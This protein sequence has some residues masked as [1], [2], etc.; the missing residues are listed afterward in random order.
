MSKQ[1][2]SITTIIL[3]AVYIGL[4]IVLLPHTAWAFRKWEPIES[5]ELFWGISSADIIS[6]VAA[7]AFESA[8]AVLTHKLAKHIEETPRSKKGINKFLYR[9]VNPI[10]FGLFIATAVS[11]LANLAHA[12]EFGGELTIFTEW[13]IPKNVYSLAFGGI[14]PFV[15]LTFA[16]VLSNVIED[17]EAP[18]PEITLANEQI[19]S[20]RQ[21]LR[22]SEARV[23][24]AEERARLAEERFAAIGDLVK[25][26]FGEDKRQR[27][28][29]A[30]QQW[31]DLPNKAIAIITGTSEAY[32]SEVIKENMLLEA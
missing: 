7:F 31:K 24:S 12:V 5:F 13:G 2:T 9:Y 27:I 23:K 18:N 29:A 11:A 14:L 4:L 30:R 28:I 15:S 6:Y 21:Q 26:L 3:W 17:E 10:S 16:R 25:Y 22:E 32:V 1:K 19:K 8:I 20:L